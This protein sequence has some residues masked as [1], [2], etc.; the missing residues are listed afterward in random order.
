M[1]ESLTD[2]GLVAERPN[3]VNTDSCDVP[4]ACPSKQ[5]DMYTNVISTDAWQWSD[6]LA[7]KVQSKHLLCDLETTCA[8]TS[9]SQACLS[10]DS[11]RGL[12]TMSQ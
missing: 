9:S 10:R 2:Q 4:P 3:M 8:K 11:I 6:Y 7:E 5:A 12:P 1:Q